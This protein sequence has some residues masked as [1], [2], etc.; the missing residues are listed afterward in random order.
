MYLCGLHEGRDVSASGKS[1]MGITMLVR[2]EC[3]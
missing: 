1:S 2:I 3:T